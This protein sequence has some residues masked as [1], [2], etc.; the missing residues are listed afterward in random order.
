MCF[1]PDAMA[2]GTVSKHTQTEILKKSKH[3]DIHVLNRLIQLLLEVHLDKN[4]VMVSDGVS[5]WA[6]LYV[7]KKKRQNY[8]LIS[9]GLQLAFIIFA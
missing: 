4:N 7:K 3:L 5:L 2:Q 8:T 6:L 9:I 1:L